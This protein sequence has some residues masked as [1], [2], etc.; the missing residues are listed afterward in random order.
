MSELPPP[1]RPPANISEIVLQSSAKPVVAA[2]SKHPPPES[3]ESIRIRQLVIL[4][5]WAIVVFLGLPIWY[6]TTSVYRAQLPLRE[7][8][9]WAEGK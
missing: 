3:K 6:C 9:D 7:M 8:E 2:A 5:F 1:G 4:S